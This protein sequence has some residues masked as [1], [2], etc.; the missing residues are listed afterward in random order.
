MSKQLRSDQLVDGI[1]LD[2]LQTGNDSD[3]E[4]QRGNDALPGA[5]KGGRTAGKDDGSR[6]TK[7]ALV[8]SSLRF[9]SSGREWAAATSQGLQVFGLDE[10][11]IF[12]PEDLTI[13]A[14]PENISHA[15]KTEKY[16][17]ALVLALH[18]SS[19][20]TEVLKAA[21]EAVP[22]KSIDIVIKSVNPKRYRDLFGFLSKQIVSLLFVK[23]LL[24]LYISCMYY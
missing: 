3:E 16:A 2:T 12:A 13:E 22:V 7:P 4:L 6:S 20:E 14:T 24:K 15:I 11:L 10:S 8:T 23:V 17:Q 18:L 1:A 21:L 19:S 9:S 5:E